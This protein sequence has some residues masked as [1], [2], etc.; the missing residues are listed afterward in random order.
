MNM[1]TLRIATAAILIMSLATTALADDVWHA[2]RTLLPGDVLRSDDI[3]AGPLARPVP[4]A[5]PASRAIIG[6]EVKRRLYDGRVL[7]DHDIGAP[8]VVKASAQ[9]D[10]IWKEGGLSLTLAGRAL[11]DGAMGDEIRVFNPMSS[12]TI[13]GTVVGDGV[14]EVRSQQ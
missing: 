14:V 3:V 10:V 11:E 2:T 1:D 9:V 7:T 12:R 6:L 4:Q 13:R 8:A 5:V